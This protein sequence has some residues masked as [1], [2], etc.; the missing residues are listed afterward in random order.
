M[1]S[2]AFQPRSNAGGV[3]QGRWRGACGVLFLLMASVAGGLAPAG[4]APLTIR[5]L[6]FSTAAEDWRSAYEGEVVSFTG[7]IVTHK[8][9]FRITLQDPTLG[10]EWA[11]IEVRAF[12]NEAPLHAVAVGDQVDFYDVRVEEFRGGT[13]PQF[14]SASRFEIVSS[15]H[16]LPD[17]VPVALADLAHPPQRERCE[18]YEGMLVAVSDVRVG[19]MDWGKA[20]DNYAL[21]D[22]DAQMWASDYYNLDLAVPP[23]PTYYVERGERYA[24]IAGIFQEYLYPAEGWDYYQLLPRGEMDYERASSYTVRDVQESTAEDGWASLL[25]GQRIALSGIVAA[26]P[27]AAGRLVLADP[28]VGP[29]W[30][31]VFLRDAGAYL[32]ALA[33]GDEIELSQALVAETGGVTELQFDAQS[34]FEVTATGRGV[35]GVWIEPGA[36][37]RAAGPETAERYEGMLVS[38]YNGDVVRRGVPEGEHLYYL[39]CGADTVLASDRESAVVVPDSTFFV[40]R[41]DR[42]GR[43]RGIVVPEAT[44]LGTRYV[45]YPRGA[46]DYEFIVGEEVLTTWGRLKSW[47]R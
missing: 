16:P 3:I 33:V 47:F 21:S 19:E 2:Q 37:A 38:I 34:T 11:G 43:L 6:Q 1:S 22:G 44:P 30:A 12:E 10:D 14:T 40:R 4:G 27:N 32:G 9:G 39:A 13:I 8:V 29:E 18:R 45:V 35:A 17:P 36:V 26:G 20:N 23:F 28:W 7:G 5:N 46:S 41:G 31:G 25:A 24:R 42:L 15:G